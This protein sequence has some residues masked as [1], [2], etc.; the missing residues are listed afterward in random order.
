MTRL[1]IL[2]FGLVVLCGSIALGLGWHA[3]WQARR[4]C[5]AMARERQATGGRQYDVKDCVAARLLSGG[6]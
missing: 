6:A 3:G 5:E 1:R 2:V 4:A